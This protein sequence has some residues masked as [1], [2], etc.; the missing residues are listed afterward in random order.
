MRRKILWTAVALCAVLGGVWAFRVDAVV[1]LGEA[2]F[3]RARCTSCH[4]TGRTPS[5]QN[6]GKRMDRKKLKQFIM[7]PDSVYRERGMQPLNSGYDRMPKPAAKEGD[8]DA[9][10]AYLMT[11]ED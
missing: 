5:L 3:N 7:D 2:A 10:V 4:V 6:V 1:R 11:L 8:V 9:I